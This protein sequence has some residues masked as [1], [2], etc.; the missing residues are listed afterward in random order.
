VIVNALQ[1]WPHPLGRGV[2]G[3][4]RFNEVQ[5]VHDHGKPEQCAV[6]V[7][8]FFRHVE[9]N[10][11]RRNPEYEQGQDL[12]ADHRSEHDEAAP[13]VR[14]EN[15]R[16]RLPDL[17]HARLHEIRQ[18]E[19]GGLTALRY[20]AERST[21]GGDA[22]RIAAEPRYQALE[23]SARELFQVIPGEVDADKEDADPAEHEGGEFEGRFLAFFQLHC[24]VSSVRKKQGKYR[25]KE[26]VSRFLH[27]RVP[28]PTKRCLPSAAR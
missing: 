11:Q 2:P 27:N 26:Y 19:G 25:G 17:H 9:R 3:S 23:F 7:H 24:R 4:P 22:R 20:E 14:P 18:N 28:G 5:A 15:D 13:R 10:P 8:E 16:C 6:A 12:Q 1:Q 21:R